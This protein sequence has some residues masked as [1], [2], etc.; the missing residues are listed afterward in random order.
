[1]IYKKAKPEVD[2][3]LFNQITEEDVQFPLF[4]RNKDETIFIKYY[5]GYKFEQISISKK[6][7]SFRGNL[8]FGFDNQVK[9][10][11]GDLRMWFYVNFRTYIKITE[12]EFEKA[13]DFI[14]KGR[15]E[16]FTRDTYKYIEPKPLTDKP[17]KHRWK[18]IEY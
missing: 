13:F 5:D 14:M 8:L 9:E 18:P 16:F 6:E 15:E 1:M 11:A 12:E 17:I 3:E 4:F 7:E 10:L 2:E